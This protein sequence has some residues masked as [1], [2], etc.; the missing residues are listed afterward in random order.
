MAARAHLV[1][2]PP[3]WAGRVVDVPDVAGRPRTVVVLRAGG[4]VATFR[5]VGDEPEG[6]AGEVWAYT[7]VTPRTGSLVLGEDD[8]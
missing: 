4:G 2:G 6:A 7:Y 5:R 3:Q 8:E 1:D